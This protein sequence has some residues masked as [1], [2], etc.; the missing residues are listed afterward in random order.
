[1]TGGGMTFTFHQHQSAA[2]RDENAA[3][4]FAA[5]CDGKDDILE[6]ARRFHS[7]TFIFSKQ[8]ARAS[9]HADVPNFAQDP[10]CHSWIPIATNK[11]NRASNATGAICQPNCRVIIF[12]APITNDPVGFAKRHGLLA[13]PTAAVRGFLR[14]NGTV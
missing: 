11:R 10:T 13:M 8:R 3:L 5:R 4:H 7:D 2:N 6:S 14:L 12:F 9:R 1:M